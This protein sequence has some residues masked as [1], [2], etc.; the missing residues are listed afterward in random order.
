MRRTPDRVLAAVEAMATEAT[1]PLL[2]DELRD[3][4]K[5]LRHQDQWARQANCGGWQSMSQGRFESG[6]H[7]RPEDCCMGPGRFAK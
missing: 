7:R 1:D 4:A 2:A 3:L 5:Y 6:C